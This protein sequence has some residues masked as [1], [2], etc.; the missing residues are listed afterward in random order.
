MKK[1]FSMVATSL[2][3]D[4]ILVTEDAKR[5]E[6][7]SLILKA[8]STT[9]NSIL[10]IT[11]NCRGGS[12]TVIYLPGFAHEQ[13]TLVVE[14]IY[15]GKTK[16]ATHLLQDFK[17]AVKSL[18]VFSGFELED[19]IA[20]QTSASLHVSDTEGK[21]ESDKTDFI[22][23]KSESLETEDG[24]IIED[25]A[26][27]ND[28][29]EL[30]ESHALENQ[31]ERCN[32]ETVCSKT[33]LGDKIIMKD[34]FYPSR[35]IIGNIGSNVLDA[36]NATKE[37]KSEV[38]HDDG[39][40]FKPKIQF[41]CDPSDP[42]ASTEETSVGIIKGDMESQNRVTEPMANIKTAKE[43]SDK[44]EDNHPTAGNIPDNAL[45]GKPR[46]QKIQS[47]KKKGKHAKERRKSKDTSKQKTCEYCGKQ[48]KGTGF[49][50]KGTKYYEHMARHKVMDKDCGCGIDFSSFI[51][52]RWHLRV[53]HEGYFPCNLCQQP[54]NSVF[55]TEALLGSHKKDKHPENKEQDLKCNV[56]ECNKTFKNRSS[57]PYHMM[58]SHDDGGPFCCSHCGKELP[59][60][61]AL[62][63]HEKRSHNEQ[64]CPVCFKLVKNLRIH[65]LDVHTEDSQ[66]RLQCD[67]CGKGFSEQ[68]KL[69][70]HK[71]NVHIK[72]RPFKC[73]Y[74]CENDIG[75]NDVSNRN[76]HERKKHGGLFNDGK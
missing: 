58:S 60:R 38:A 45:Q 31:F 14:L 68:S 47:K 44:P 34:I 29:K 49:K 37:D 52:K 72:T 57:I 40:E 28:V 30:F 35:Q 74:L 3:K 63:A 1:V 53:V 9:F 46:Q 27:K 19:N 15:L 17:A 24:E 23:S 66:L 76:S 18:G 5:L 65:T 71:M 2:P 73:R 11:K 75:Y 13:L 69:K 7:H 55:A 25:S 51:K 10:H 62:N 26:N 39:K 59:S 22:N 56:P 61:L 20:K 16:V 6:A 36:F 21:R 64:S 4:V 41:K 67:S 50:Y 70:K 43:E 32:I 48:F 8:A 42:G 33:T 12:N 54:S